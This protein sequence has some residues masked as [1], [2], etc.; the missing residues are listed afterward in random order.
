MSGVYLRNAITS[1]RSLAGSV[2]PVAKNDSCIKTEAGIY[3]FMPLKSHV[4]QMAEAT[5]RQFQLHKVY[6]H[7]PLTFSKIAPKDEHSWFQFSSFFAK[8]PSCF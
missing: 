4:L 1:H 2:C 6:K 3:N 8:T 5:T 7:V